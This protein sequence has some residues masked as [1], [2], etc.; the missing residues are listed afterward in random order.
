MQK[1]IF[2]ANVSSSIPNNKNTNHQKENDRDDNTDSSNDLFQRAILPRIHV[3]LCRRNKPAIVVTA[4]RWNGNK[5]D[6]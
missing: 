5:I 6:E 1:K 3:E 4:A 2:C